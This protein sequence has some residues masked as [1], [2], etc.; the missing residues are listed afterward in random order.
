MQGRVA[1]YS[2]QLEKAHTNQ[3]RCSTA[4]P[5]PQKRKACYIPIWNGLLLHYISPCPKY[6]GASLEFH[7]GNSW[8]WE[9][10]VVCCESIWAKT[11]LQSRCQ[12]AAI[13]WRDHWCWR[14]CF[15][16]DLL[17][18]WMISAGCWQEPQFPT[19]WISS[20]GWYPQ[21]MATGF[22]QS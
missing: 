21:D 4:P 17:G 10:A 5:S 19:L 3:Q 11:H 15:Q 14:I 9:P 12:Q 6:M 1:T 20:L 18:G 7:L 8:G 13:I 2:S 16:D 22:P